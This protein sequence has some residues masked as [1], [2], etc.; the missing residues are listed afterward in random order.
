MLDFIA[1]Y[2]DVAAKLNFSF[3]DLGGANEVKSRFAGPAACNCEPA[4]GGYLRR[5]T[6]ISRAG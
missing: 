3:A 4:A 6:Q 2:R 5:G 1:L